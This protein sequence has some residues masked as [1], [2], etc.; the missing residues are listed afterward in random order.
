[1]MTLT[2]FSVSTTYCNI[3]LFNHHLRSG[4]I[5]LLSDCP[6]GCVSSGTGESGK[7]TFIRQMRIIHGRGFSEEE[8]RDFAKLIYQNIFTAVKAMTRAMITLKLPYAY[9]ENEVRVWLHTVQS[10]WPNHE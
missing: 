2:L 7:T 6:L 4:H 9:P 8:R 1:M 3:A 10:N 5:V